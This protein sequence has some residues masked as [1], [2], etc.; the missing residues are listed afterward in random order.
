[1]ANIK[2]GT[3]G[4][5]DIMAEGF[6]FDNLRIVT[7]AVANYVKSKSANQTGIVIG[8]DARFLS[9]KFAQEV[10]NILAA[11]EIKVYFPPREIPTPVTAFAV[12][13]LRAFGA[14]M[15][16]ASHNPPEYNGFKFIPEYAG[17]AFPEITKQIEENIKDVMLTNKIQRYDSFKEALNSGFIEEIDVTESYFEH[18]KKL[19][20][21]E[22]LKSINNKVVIDPLYGAGRGFLEKFLTSLGIEIQTIHTN[23][24]PLF[25]G[26][27]PEPSEKFLKS[28][29]NMVK[30]TNACMGL[31]L[32]GDAD[33]F[34]VIDSKAEFIKPN[35]LISILAVHLIKHKKLNGALV[36]TVST[37]HLIDRI[38][39]KYGVKVY[40]VPVGFKY[41][42]EKMLNEKIIIGG[43]ESGGLS[44]FG[45]IPEKDGILADL[46]ALE[47]YAIERKPLSDVLNDIMREIGTLHS[48]KINVHVKPDKKEQLINNLKENPPEYIA[49]MKV[50]N[51]LTIDGVK[52]ILRDGS[53]VLL[54]PSG[55]EPLVRFY[56]EATSIELL[57]R[58]LSWGN[59]YLSN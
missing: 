10:A 36:R 20:D 16:T 18:L 30:T 21:I 13:H 5:R 7:Q 9:D 11:N 47:T 25:G 51:V 31:S 40:E 8:Y 43:E 23:R 14:I 59:D 4:W 57:N 38:G 41:I 39:E 53:W 24:D 22:A 50:T 55:T 37:T 19:I 26:G 17:P 28:L 58:L 6:T 12:K 46:L 56:A 44:I 52:L 29:K 3:D 45:H 49:N 27:M 2:F 15:I 32:D 54:R 34:G 35:Q 1:M 33:R 48:D 42:A